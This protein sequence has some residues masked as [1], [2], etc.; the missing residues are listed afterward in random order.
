M[1]SEFKD[2]IAAATEAGEMEGKMADLDI[3]LT[4]T[5]LGEESEDPL[6]KAEVYAERLGATLSSSPTG[7]AFINGKHF[8]MNE[9]CRDSMC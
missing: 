9:V 1:R 5:N 2:L 3:I 8:D 7:H 6:K 4:G